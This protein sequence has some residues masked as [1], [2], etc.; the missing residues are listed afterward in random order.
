MLGGREEA[1]K[2]ILTLTR[3]WLKDKI[4]SELPGVKCVRQKDRRKVENHLF[5]TVLKHVKKT[6]FAVP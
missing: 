6:W 2:H 4:L 1:Q 5:F 3:K